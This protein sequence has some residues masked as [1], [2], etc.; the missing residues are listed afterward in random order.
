MR[1]MLGAAMVIVALGGATVFRW[2]STPGAPGSN[3]L[4]ASPPL[5]SARVLASPPP[6]TSVH[7]VAEPLEFLSS[8]PA[9][10]LVLLPGV[11]PVLANRLVAA[12]TEHGPFR[13]WG[14]VDRVRGIG[15][16][17]IERLKSMKRGR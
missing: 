5:D 9:E 14:D 12:R 17:T 3:F 11:G 4:T 1:R 7:F 13:S 10:S 2:W 16:K 6:S 15:P 8:A